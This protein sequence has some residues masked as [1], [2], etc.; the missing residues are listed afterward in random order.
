[1][2][3]INED[4][5]ESMEYDKIN[6]VAKEFSVK[7][8]EV[9]RYIDEIWNKI[10]RCK[11]KESMDDITRL[12]TYLESILNYVNNLKNMTKSNIK[13]E[14][15]FEKFILLEKAMNIPDYILIGDLMKYEIKPIITDWRAII[16]KISETYTK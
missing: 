12:F 7:C 8:E 15:I 4:A 11:F 6:I 5:I 10:I 14:E 1:M 3:I 2:N 16:D 9:E 13:V